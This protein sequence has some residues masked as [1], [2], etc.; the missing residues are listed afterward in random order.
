MEYRIIR[1][2]SIPQVWKYAGEMPILYAMH[3]AGGMV[4]TQQDAILPRRPQSAVLREPFGKPGQ[5]HG[6]ITRRDYLPLS[7]Y[8]TFPN[9]QIPGYDHCDSQKHNSQ[10]IRRIQHGEFSIAAM[11]QHSRLCKHTNDIKSYANDQ[12]LVIYDDMDAPSLYGH[13]DEHG[14]FATATRLGFLHLSTFSLPSSK[15]DCEDAQVH[16]LEQWFGLLPRRSGVARAPLVRPRR[17]RRWRPSNQWV[18]TLPLFTFVN[19][20]AGCSSSC[21]GRMH[22]YYSNSL[23]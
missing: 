20:T 1:H 23:P 9:S 18:F 4:P 22:Y 2:N 8:A 14:T 12:R 19:P 6:D 16:H 7:P 15:K 5:H 3:Q 21:T 17:D 11:T 13:F 10:Y